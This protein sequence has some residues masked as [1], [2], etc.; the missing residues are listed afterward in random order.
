[1]IDWELAVKIAA[2]GFG[3]VFILLTLLAF[4]VWL[5]KEVAVRIEARKPS[6]KK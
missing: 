6:D 1:M 3:L 5:T 4:S 2:G